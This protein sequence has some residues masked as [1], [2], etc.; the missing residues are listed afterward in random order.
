MATNVN[1]Y[2]GLKYEDEGQIGLLAFAP[3]SLPTTHGAQS[4][5]A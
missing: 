3:A 2:S 1:S 5:R 4:R